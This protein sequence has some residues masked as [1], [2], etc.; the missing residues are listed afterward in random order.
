MVDLETIEVGGDAALAD[1]F[2]DRAA[3]RLE[4]AGGVVAEQGRARRVGEA[5]GDAGLAFTQSG[6]NPGERATGA[7]G[8]NETVDLAAGLLPDFRAGGFE[9]GLAVGYIVELVRPDRAIGFLA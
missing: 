5:D 3:L 9:M 2:G 4:L 6:G 8:A 7:D 1:T